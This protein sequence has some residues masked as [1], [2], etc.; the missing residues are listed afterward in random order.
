MGSADGIPSRPTVPI[1]DL[2]A[3]MP[4][5]KAGMKLGDEIIGCGWATITGLE[6]MIETSE[7]DKGSS[8]SRSRYC[9]MA[10]C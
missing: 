3:G 8:L 6:A 2:E 7:E 1:T 9:G 4:A 10:S 5:E